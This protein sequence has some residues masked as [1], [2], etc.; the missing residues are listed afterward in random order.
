MGAYNLQTRENDLYK[1]NVRNSN[2]S[3]SHQNCFDG[4]SDHN[5]VDAVQAYETKS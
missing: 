1:I 5:R 3:S 2:E 4:L